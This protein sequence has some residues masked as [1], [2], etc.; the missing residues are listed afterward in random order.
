MTTQLKTPSSRTALLL[1]CVLA[2]Y[3]LVGLLG[4]VQEDAYITFRTAFN[5]ADHGELTFNL[6]ERHSG[7]TSLLYPHLI[8]VIRALSGEAAISIVLAL[9]SAAVLVAAWL[10]A[11]ML[12]DE[13][14]LPASARMPLAGSI[15]LLPASIT[16]AARGMET[17][18]VVLLFVVGLRA[19]RRPASLAAVLPTLL[20]PLIRPDAVAF[21]FIVAL[22]ASAQQRSLAWRHLV[23][24]LGSFGLF[25]A[26]NRVLLGSF[27]PPTVAAKGRELGTRDVWDILGGQA[28]VFF[29]SFLFGPLNTH[30]LGPIALP[31]GI[32]GV[33]VCLGTLWWAL[34]RSQ[35]RSAGQVLAIAT[36]PAAYG[37]GGVLFGWYLWPSWFL[38]Q[39]LVV[40]LV[41][42]A[43]TRLHKGRRAVA[44][45]GLVCSILALAGARVALAASKGFQ[46]ST[47]R[48]SVGRYIAD[49]ADPADTLFLEP[50]G[51]IPFHAG[52]RTIDEVGLASPVVLR[53]MNRH[54]R[55]WWIETLRGERPNYLVQRAHM[56]DHRTYQGYA[57]TAEEAAWF[58]RHYELIRPFEYRPETAPQVLRPFAR[59]GSHSPYYVYRLRD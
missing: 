44:T 5:L 6:G 37:I 28:Q 10:M 42:R 35:W 56:L 8:A 49:V 50:A 12:T 47:F 16:L 36:V 54:P 55:R 11:D 52:L 19:T 57:L 34:R 3:A 31:L 14:Q 46:E 51:Y 29:D 39:S 40:A 45:I 9:N 13:W 33:L 17:P 58:D 26:A 25:F 4:D 41:A 1:G 32:V 27:L 38:Y 2:T 23:S 22:V 15:A 18:Y 20:L 24:W 48:A 59:L 21:G 30:L 43:V 7:A 53:Y